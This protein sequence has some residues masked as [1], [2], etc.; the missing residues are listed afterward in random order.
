MSMQPDIQ[1]IWNWQTIFAHPLFA[2]MLGAIVSAILTYFITAR[3]EKKRQFHQLRI[4][5]LSERLKAHQQA[6]TFLL[7]MN[8]GQPDARFYFDDFNR[9][10]KKNCLYLNPKSRH[11]LR[12]ML[13]YYRDAHIPHLT[14]DR[15][16]IEG[17]RRLR[18]EGIKIIRKSIGLPSI[19]Q[20]GNRSRRRSIRE[21][22][23]VMKKVWWGIFFG[24]LVGVI[25]LAPESAFSNNFRELLIVLTAPAFITAV[26]PFFQDFLKSFLVEWGKNLANKQDMEKLTKQVEEIKLQHSKLLEDHKFEN[27][28]RVA[29]LDKR[30][31]VNQ[32]AYGLVYGMTLEELD[33]ES[34]RRECDD[35]WNKNCLYLSEEVRAKFRLAQFHLQNAR[36]YSEMTLAELAEYNTVMA[37]ALTEIEK[38]MGLPPITKIEVG[39]SE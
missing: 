4:G 20:G 18:K 11:K 3:V 7:N 14:T 36:P 29:A 15:D 38:S 2:L 31:E 16:K 21:R 24:A 1:T 5:A 39:K 28:L 13:I 30:L 6:Y 12:V 33:P 9:W 34:H 22:R 26:W 37:S 32:E 25:I 27:Q 23:K 19:I 8:I 17:C 35:W 10:W